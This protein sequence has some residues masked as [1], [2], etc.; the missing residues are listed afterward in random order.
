MR[1]KHIIAYTVRHFVSVML[2]VIIALLSV[3]VLSCSSKTDNNAKKFKTSLLY[4]SQVSMPIVNMDVNGQNVKFIL[5]TGSEMTIVGRKFYYANKDAFTVTNKMMFSASTING[6][7]TDSAYTALVQI[8]SVPTNV[9]IMDI[10]DLIRNTYTST[11]Q[12]I[13]GIIGADY[14]YNNNAVIDFGACT[15]KVNTQK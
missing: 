1:T 15:M 12:I 3:Q 7:M 13:N 2:V 5:D 11:G 10:Q 14:L 4:H 8:D 6:V 9:V